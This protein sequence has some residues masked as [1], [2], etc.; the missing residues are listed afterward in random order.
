MQ[1]Q[2]VKVN[3]GKEKKEKEGFTGLRL[4]P[5]GSLRVNRSIINTRE[6]QRRSSHNHPIVPLANFAASHVDDQ[7]RK[8]VTAQELMPKSTAFPSP[9]LSLHFLF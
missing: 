7:P 8:A 1:I 2:G 4:R 9:T 5:S 6:K 3:Y